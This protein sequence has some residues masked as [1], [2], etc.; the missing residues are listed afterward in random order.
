LKYLFISKDVFSQ[1]YE[2]LAQLQLL[3]RVIVIDSYTD[4]IEY[5]RGDRQS[6]RTIIERDMSV[7]SDSKADNYRWQMAARLVV[8]DVFKR[9]YKQMGV[10]GVARQDRILSIA[11]SF[12]ESG[13]FS[14]EQIAEAL[15]EDLDIVIDVL[16]DAGMYKVVNT[17]IDYDGKRTVFLTVADKGIAT[18]SWS[19]ISKDLSDAE[20][21]QYERAKAEYSLQRAQTKLQDVYPEHRIGRYRQSVAGAVTIKKEDVTSRQATT[22]AALG[23][24]EGRGND[25]KVV[26]GVPIG[27]NRA[28]VQSTVSTVNRGLARNGFGRIEDNKQVITF[29]IDPTDAEKTR[30][31]QEKAMQKAQ[32]GLAPDGRIV[33]FA[34]Q[35]EKGPQLAGKTQEQYKGQGNISVVPDAYSDASPE[36]DIYPDIMLRVALGRDIAFYYTGRDTQDALARINSLLTKVIDGFAPI[37]TIDDLLNILKP[38]RIR[39]IDFKTITDWQKAQEATATSL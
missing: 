29:E 26:V 9:E 33:L 12:S 3:D 31:N 1:N 30:Q 24:S 22:V 17:S 25:V 11:S 19:D 6:D 4:R 16:V 32:E 2:R 7:L 8:S 23:A 36:Q 27:M 10:D 21:A 13:M 15:K 14:P 28:N 37:V 38:L 5:Y 34:P 20:I 18:F 39:P 35:I